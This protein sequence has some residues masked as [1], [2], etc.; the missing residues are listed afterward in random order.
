MASEIPWIKT[1]QAKLGAFGFKKPPLK[2]KL[3]QK[4]KLR[5][6]RDLL[7]SVQKATGFPAGLFTDEVMKAS[8]GAFREWSKD[9]K[10]MKASTAAFK[11]WSKDNK[12]GFLKRIH[13]CVEAA[14]GRRLN[15]TAEKAAAGLEPENTN[16]V[17]QGLADA[18]VL[19]KEGKVTMGPVLK[20][21]GSTG[22]GGY[23]SSANQ[24]DDGE[25]AA[26][27]AAAAAEK[28]A[29]EAERK[30]AH[31]E[32]A[33]RKAK[34]AVDEERRRAAAEKAA[35]RKA[36]KE[37][38]ERR[39]RQQEQQANKEAAAAAAPSSQETSADDSQKINVQ[40]PASLEE[41]IATSK[42]L[43]SPLIKRAPM[44]DKFL[45]RP[46]AK[47]ILDVILS[48]IKA[49]GFLDGLYTPEELDPQEYKQQ[50]K[51]L[52]NRMIAMFIKKTIKFT[53][54]AIGSA[55]PVNINDVM[56]GVEA[57]K[58]NMLFHALAKAAM[59]NVSSDVI[60][61]RM[62]GGKSK[63]D[64]SPSVRKPPES[65]TSEAEGG[66]A[67][68]SSS[69]SSNKPQ[70][71]EERSSKR[72]TRSSGGDT[73]SSNKEATDLRQLAL[74]AAAEGA[75]DK[76]VAMPKLNIG[77]ITSKPADEATAAYHKAA[78][79]EE[80]EMRSAR[81]TT[82]PMTAR[83]A[84]PKVRSHL[85]E[86]KKT[87]ADM[88]K[89]STGLIT[90]DNAG[91]DLEEDDDDDDDDGLGIK[92]EAGQPN[93]N[94]RHGKLVS[95][96]LRFQNKHER[97]DGNDESKADD[98][99]TQFRFGRLKKKSGGASNF[100]SEEQI[101]FLREKIQA[102]CQSA[103]PLGKC[104]DYVCEDME[105][106]NK[107][108]AQW[109]R[110]YDAE[111]EVQKEASKTTEGSLAPLRQ[112]LAD[113]DKEIL[114]EQESTVKLQAQGKEGEII[115]NERVIDGCLK[116]LSGI[117]ADH[118][119]TAPSGSNKCDEHVDDGAPFPTVHLLLIEGGEG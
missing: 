112:T 115:M 81:P 114:Q 55:L 96:I 72:S 111:K 25:A 56:R 86:E 48:V 113:L 7:V 69:S 19:T 33:E 99:G 73:G 42:T 68:N 70:Q 106:M 76:A 119:E 40:E 11:E 53:S 41:G 79:E 62:R 116:T 118:A 54:L 78:E 57:A 37:E 23:P 4:P 63:R 51:K 98:D 38:A 95:D 90:E 6:I 74:S 36:A 18:A 84:P 80:R 60:R 30:R 102:L 64:P 34:A 43:L 12:V 83:R 85:V 110:V 49:T 1:S 22:W 45:T 66:T 5:F 108:L 27:A 59:A 77:N 75:N 103:T 92:M 82:R 87:I 24:P 46:P 61:S 13:A 94:E 93:A 35:R 21:V 109:T 65:T 58:T 89:E 10:V 3:L 47:F 9:N 97:K 88:D 44:K 20:K 39:R 101:I 26:A 17:L 91:E 104:I 29:E 117:D 2:E 100:Y 105:S 71:Q 28:E 15:F 8:T 107:E 52:R 32:E 16:L 14:T 31:A 67:D 50:D